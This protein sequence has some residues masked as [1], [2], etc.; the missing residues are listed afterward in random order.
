[1][2]NK[3]RII[4]V[5]CVTLSMGLSAVAAGFRYE[6]NWDG[7]ITLL[8]HVGTVPETLEMPVAY[9]ASTWTERVEPCRRSAHGLFLLVL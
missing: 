4:G 8:Q 9:T 1:M 7:T 2:R 5:L 3:M 6:A